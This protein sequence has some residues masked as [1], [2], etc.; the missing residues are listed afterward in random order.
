MRDEWKRF[1][2]GLGLPIE[3]LHRNE[4]VERYGMH[5]VALPAVFLKTSGKL[6]AWIGRDEIDR[7]RTL[8][9]LQQLV[10]ARLQTV[11]VR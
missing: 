2:D 9:D 7:C 1:V 3:F 11:G 4:L 8:A 6:Q 10:Q 5:G